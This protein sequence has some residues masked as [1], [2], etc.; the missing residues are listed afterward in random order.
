MGNGMNKVLPGLYVGSY[1][2]S[3]DINQL[4]KFEISHVI[5]IH[6]SPKR[7]YPNLHY[8]MIMAADTPDQNLTQYFPICNDFIHSA[9]L[10]EKNVLIHCLAGKDDKIVYINR[11]LINLVYYTHTFF[12]E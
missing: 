4:E 12:Q 10:Q 5:A 1:R 6:D 2:D 11:N 7:L 9:R 3:K 8:L